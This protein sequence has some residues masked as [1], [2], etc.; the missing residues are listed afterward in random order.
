MSYSV[1]V[2][3]NGPSDALNV[4]VVDN[5]PDVKQAIYVF[6]TGGCTLAAN[7]LTC[8]L[9]TI[10]AGASKSFNVHE[11]VKGKKGAIDN[12]A[13]AFTT[14]FDPNTVNNV[15]IRTVLIGGAVK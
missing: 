14:T 13:T 8:N 5:L 11:T 2:T 15:S 1:Q 7:T 4:V 12:K 9:G 6:D 3:N 10:A